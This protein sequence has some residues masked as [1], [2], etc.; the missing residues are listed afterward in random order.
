MRINWITSFPGAHLTK[1]FILSICFCAVIAEGQRAMENTNG[2]QS[3]EFHGQQFTGVTKVKVLPDFRIL[4]THDKGLASGKFE[5]F[6]PD[7]LSSW[8]IIKE[9]FE[10]LKSAVLSQKQLSE[11]KRIEV[12]SKQKENRDKLMPT[13]LPGFTTDL[14]HDSIQNADLKCDVVLKRI[15]EANYIVFGLGS[16]RPGIELIGTES[17]ICAVQFSVRYTGSAQDRLFLKKC[18]EIASDFD[19]TFALWVS[20]EI[21][22]L[23]A[24]PGTRYDN[25]KSV[26]DRQYFVTGVT[27]EDHLTIVFGIKS[28]D[29]DIKMHFLDSKKLLKSKV[30][31]PLKPLW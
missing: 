21:D 17:N 27:W 22:N 19:A 7:F 13:S 5:D 31:F 2:W 6:P 28:N 9:N 14:L 16:R 20:Q 23:T 24:H 18:I 25:K 11:K 30:T 15:A 3:V 29:Y 12:E 4:I 1:F 10:K 26:D 8:G